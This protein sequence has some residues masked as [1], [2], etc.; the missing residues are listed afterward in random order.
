M[1][2]PVNIC[3]HVPSF[4]KSDKIHKFPCTTVLID[5]LYKYLDFFL[6]SLANNVITNLSF[7]FNSDKFLL[8]L[9]NY[10]YSTVPLLVI[11]LALVLIGYK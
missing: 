9:C 4:F 7:K 5:F 6:I 10:L 3:A 2:L 11:V 8:C 1:N